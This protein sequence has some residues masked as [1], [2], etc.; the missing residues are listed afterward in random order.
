MEVYKFPTS[1]CRKNRH[2]EYKDYYYLFNRLL[3]IITKLL[4]KFFYLSVMPQFPSHF[5][6]L[7]R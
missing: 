7:S 6:P 4:C 5:L 1:V 3:V 2:T